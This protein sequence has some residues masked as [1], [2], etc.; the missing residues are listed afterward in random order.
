MYLI[1]CNIKN[2]GDDLNTPLIKYITGEIPTY[3]KHKF[4]PPSGVDIYLV[5]GSILRFAT[6]YT[7][8]WGPGFISLKDRMKC[9]PKEIHAVRGPLSRKKLLTQGI[10]CPKIYGDPALLYPRFYKPKN[11]KKKYKLG[12]IP[13]YID[14]KVPTVDLFRNKS[15][16]FVIDIQG[17]INQVVDDI[18]SCERIASSCLHGIIC[19][20]AYGIPSTWIKFSNRVIGKGFKFKDYFA[21]VGRKDTEPL[22][23]KKDITIQKILDQFYEYKLNIDLD[24]LYEVCPFKISHR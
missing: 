13:H 8:V 20:D 9:C 14:K 5:V 19:A 18:C 16:I 12:I 7:A 21:S 17:P 2:W 22:V 4:I 11:I 23:I 10:A 24:K 3:V 1:R 6:K 15:D